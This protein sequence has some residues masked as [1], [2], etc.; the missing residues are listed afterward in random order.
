[1]NGEQVCTYHNCHSLLLMKSKHL[2]IVVVYSNNGRILPWIDIKKCRLENMSSA[3]LSSDVGLNYCHYCIDFLISFISLHP[4]VLNRSSQHCGWNC[5]ISNL[6]N[7]RWCFLMPNTV[8]NTSFSSK[9]LLNEYDF[10]FS[11]FMW[12]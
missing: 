10:L 7:L 3:A 4:L 5:K 9:S 6:D 11:F 2:C 12:S 1:M 8:Q